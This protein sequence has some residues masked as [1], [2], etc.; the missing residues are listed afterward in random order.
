MFCN[1]A[2]RYLFQIS[3]RTYLDGRVSHV[4]FLFVLIAE[5]SIT[6]SPQLLSSTPKEGWE[7]NVNSIIVVAPNNYI[8]LSDNYSR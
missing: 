5:T 1:L 4:I 7:Y 3:R 6:S 8:Q 2:Q